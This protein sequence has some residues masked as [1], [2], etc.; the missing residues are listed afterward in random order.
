[1][2]LAHTW[3]I[4]TGLACATPTLAAAADHSAFYVC[5]LRV[6]GTDGAAASERLYLSPVF[7]ADVQTPDEVTVSWTMHVL[8]MLSLPSNN[9]AYRHCFKSVREQDA[10][11]MLAKL[12]Q[13]A[14]L[15]G[16]KVTPVDWRYSPG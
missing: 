12:Q 4:A 5:E 15:Q 7:S 13:D 9:G 2:S 11:A 8:K 10:Q 16:Q 6:P 14:K 1:V 3:A